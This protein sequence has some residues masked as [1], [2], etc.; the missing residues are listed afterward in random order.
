M[1]VFIEPKIEIVI[2]E[3]ND[4]LTESG[5]EEPIVP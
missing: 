2:F 4:I 5:W 1:K 3:E